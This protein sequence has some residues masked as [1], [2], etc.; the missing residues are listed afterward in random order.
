ML[1]DAR[2]RDPELLLHHRT[3]LTGRPLAINKQLED[4]SADRIT[5][6]IEGVHLAMLPRTICAL[7]GNRDVILIGLDGHDCE[8]TPAGRRLL[9]TD[10]HVVLGV[11]QPGGATRVRSGRHPRG[12]PGG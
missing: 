9:P 5:E 6:N 7:Q 1:R 11:G 4:P 3:D 12:T 2:L 8:T 10:P